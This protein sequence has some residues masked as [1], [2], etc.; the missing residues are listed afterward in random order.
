VC[1]FFVEIF[2]LFTGKTTG[3][4]GS[5]FYNHR[6]REGM[7]PKIYIDIVFPV[8]WG[9]DAFLLWMAG[10]IL[11]LRRKRWRFA[12]GGL[13]AAVC[14]CAWL[15]FLQRSGGVLFSLLLLAGGVFIAYTPKSG[16][17]FLRLMGTTLLSSFLLGGGAQLL[18]TFTQAQRLFGQGLIVERIYPWWLLPWAVLLAYVLLKLGAGWIETHICRR[19]EFCTVAVFRQGRCAEVRTLID[20]GNGLKQ[21]DDRGVAI[22]EMQAVLPLFSA[23]EGIRLLSGSRKASIPHV[24]GKTISM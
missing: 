2:L 16:K 12:F 22:L 23:E 15:F 24:T 4:A 6:R 14:D 7:E 9:M 19:R 17:I 5:S 21:A 11:G 3:F 20:T 8:T 10:R 1:S 13:F 18:F